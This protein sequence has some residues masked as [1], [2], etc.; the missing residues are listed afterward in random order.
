VAVDETLA[1]EDFGEG[2]EFEVAAEQKRR[3]DGGT[4]RRRERIV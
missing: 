3:S 2:F 4:E 1:L